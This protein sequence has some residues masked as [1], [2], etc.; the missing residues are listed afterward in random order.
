V[1]KVLWQ[2]YVQGWKSGATG[3]VTFTDFYINT[4][5]LV[6]PVVLFTV[7]SCSLVAYGFARFDFPFK[8]IL[9]PVMIATLML[10]NT[11]IIIPRYI[12]FN[13][14]GWIDSYLPFYIPA[15]LGWVSMGIAAFCDGCIRLLFRVLDCGAYFT[16]EEDRGITMPRSFA[17]LYGIFLFLVMS[18]S[19]VSNPHLYRILA[20]C[21]FV[22]ALPCAY[23]GLSAGVSRIRDRWA[24]ASFYHHAPSHSPVP[25]V[26]VSVFMI[27]FFGF[28][29]AF[30]LTATAGA[31]LVV[32]K[33]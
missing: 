3:N 22:F 27:L 5:V 13:Q 6:I 8:K 29:T 30:T 10:P 1:Q 12:L 7:C 32:L 18:T 26:L 21:H 4:F 25:A 20:N 2:N 23:V 24:E 9:F 28:P 33:R 16:P 19:S 31:A 17:V 15:L 14:F 11:V